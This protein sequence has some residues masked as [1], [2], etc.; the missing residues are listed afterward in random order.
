MD[1]WTREK[2]RY[3][4]REYPSGSMVYVLKD[5]DAQGEVKHRLCPNCFQNGAKSILQVVNKHSGGEVVACLPCDK[6]ITLSNFRGYHS[7]PDD[8]GITGY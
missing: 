6:Q 3:E 5:A 4:L 2:S 7:D 8:R 1:D